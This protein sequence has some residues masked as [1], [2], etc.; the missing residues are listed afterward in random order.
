MRYE[1][2]RKVLRMLMPHDMLPQTK[3]PSLDFNRL[4]ANSDNEQASKNGTNKYTI[5]R[6]VSIFPAMWNN[7]VTIISVIMLAKPKIPSRAST[8]SEKLFLQL[9]SNSAILW[10]TLRAI[11]VIPAR[12]TK[13]SREDTAQIKPKT[14]SVMR[15]AKTINGG[16]TAKSIVI[17]TL[18]RIYPIWA[19]K[20]SNRL[21]FGKLTDSKNSFFRFGTGA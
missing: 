13:G 2:E 21:V 14:F 20:K 10:D 15:D 11:S 12:A 3:T 16:T 7:A 18:L 1:L 8:I 19:S 17:H 5:R 9:I 4:K 6:G